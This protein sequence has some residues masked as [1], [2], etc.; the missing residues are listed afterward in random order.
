MDESDITPVFCAEIAPHLHGCIG[1]TEG[2]IFPTSL[3]FF[4]VHSDF[5]DTGG[6]LFSLH[7]MYWP[8]RG[9]TNLEFDKKHSLF[10]IIRN[11]QKLKALALID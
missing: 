6:T 5:T 4:G 9:F 8:A 7:I 11:Y 3:F 10:K 2:V 1:D